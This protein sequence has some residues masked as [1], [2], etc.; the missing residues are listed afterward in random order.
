[1]T[2]DITSFNK[3]NIVDSCAI[4]N[5]LSCNLLY[6]RTL[7]NK[8]YFSVT[9]FVEYECLTKVRSSPSDKD[10]QIQYRLRKEIGCSN[11]KTCSLSID[12]LQD[13][14]L[15][16]ARKNLGMGELSSIA[17]AMKIN[18]SFLTDDQPA[19]KFAASILGKDKVQ[20]TPHLL[21]YFIFERIII[22]NEVNEIIGEHNSFDRPLEPYFRE[23]YGEAMRIQL[24]IKK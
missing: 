6:T 12:D 2:I 19:R 16:K 15:L 7:S 9:K 24:M 8:C 23:V 5:I 1:M 17:F 21:G 14:Q 22:D 13:I 20:T 18:Q 3:I 11:I 4:W 10:I